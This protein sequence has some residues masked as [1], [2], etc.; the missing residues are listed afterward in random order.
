MIF[1]SKKAFTMIEIMIVITIIAILSV[2]FYIPYNFYSNISRVKVS[3]EILTQTLN[4]GKSS[5]AW[6]VTSPYMDAK[7]QNI[8]I[9]IKKWNNFIDMIWFDYDYSWSLSRHYWHYI[10]NIDLE[11]NV[12]I[13]KIKTLNSSTEFDET[14]LYYKAPNWELTIYSWPSSIY[15]TWWLEITLGYKWLTSWVLSRNILIK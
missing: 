9:F 15:W 8:A 6:V 13:S 3:K 14:I 1:Q 12:E 7:N 5:V 2:G 10:K 11:S 4:E